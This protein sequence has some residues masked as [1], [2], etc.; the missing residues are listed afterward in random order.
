MPFPPPG[1]LSD[2]G[3]RPVSLALADGVFTSAPPGKPISHVYT[4]I[5][6]L[7]TFL[8]APLS[9][10]TPVK[11]L[12]VEGNSFFLPHTSLHKILQADVIS[13]SS[14]LITHGSFFFFSSVP[15][16]Q[17]SLYPPPIIPVTVEG[18]FPFADCLFHVCLLHQPINV[19]SPCA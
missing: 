6:V 19:M 2:P 7:F 11:N 14:L 12:G 15:G 4:L 3:I 13:L 5:I 17:S 8:F 10:I 16:F 18:Q 9:F 1:D